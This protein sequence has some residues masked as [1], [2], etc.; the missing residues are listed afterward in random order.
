MVQVSNG[1]AQIDSV[2]EFLDPNEVKVVLDNNSDAIYF[3]R[4]PIPSRKKWEGNIPMLKQV[5]IIPF[6]RD[7]LLQFNATPQ[8]PL[9]KIESIDMLRI[10]ESGG[11]VRMVPMEAETFSVDTPKDLQK[12][13][14][15]M[16]NDKLI[17]KYCN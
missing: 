5:C 15:A 12:V 8:T 7:Y 2:D 9:E 3:S 4:E 10:I 6:R 1:Y 16:T 17:S 11:K 14:K 13:I